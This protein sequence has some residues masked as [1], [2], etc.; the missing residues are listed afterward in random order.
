MLTAV[1]VFGAEPKETRSADGDAQAET[2][3]QAT[4]AAGPASGG[5]AATT[6]TSAES[7]SQ[8]VQV[9]ETEFKITLSPATLHAGPVTFQIKNTGK[10]AHDLTIVGG[11]K[12]KLIPP[13]GSATLQATLDRKSVVQGRWVARDRRAMMEEKTT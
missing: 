6:A 5:P 7:Q 9:S 8:T 13:G 1:E 4:A 11:P 3:A 10:I 12:S 2:E